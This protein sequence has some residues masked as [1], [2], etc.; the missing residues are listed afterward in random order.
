LAD[1]I[2]VTVGMA[3]KNNESTIQKTIRSVLNQ[4]FPHELMEII[5]VDGN[6][7]DQTLKIIR[8]NVAKSDIRTKIFPTME[9]G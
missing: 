7:R 3:V 8:S 4:D 1:K 9:A 6:S 2:K 5:V